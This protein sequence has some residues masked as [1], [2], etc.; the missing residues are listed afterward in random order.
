MRPKPCIIII[1]NWIGYCFEPQHF[2]SINQAYKYGK[3][4]LGG[5]C[6]R[7]FGLNGKIIRSG[8]CE[9]D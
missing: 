9:P 3:N 6:F 1:N 8:Y 5:F 4:F 2:P 7:I